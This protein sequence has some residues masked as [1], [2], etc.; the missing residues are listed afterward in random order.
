MALGIG[1]CAQ[2]GFPPGGPEDRTP[3]TIVSAFPDS[4]AT[5]VELGSAMTVLFSEK[6]NRRSVEAARLRS[7]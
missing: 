6:M 5:G 3:P 2:K 7:R 1:S 4:G